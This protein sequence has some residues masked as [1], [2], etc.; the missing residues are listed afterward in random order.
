MMQAAYQ[1]FGSEFAAL[2]SWVMAKVLWD[3]SLKVP[4]L[5]DDFICGYY[6]HAAGDI[7]AY[8]DLLYAT[9][10]AHLDTMRKPEGGIRYPMTA[11]FLS[12][13]FLDEATRIFASAEEHCPYGEAHRRVELAKLPILYVKLMQGPDAWAD[14]Y[15]AVLAEF[16]AIARR[17]KVQYLREG[18]PDLEE[19]LKGWR[20]SV[21]VKQSML[22]IKEGEV[23]IRPLAP[24]WRFATDPKDVG[25]KESW[26][27][28]KLD[29]GRWAVV[30][31]DKGNGWEAQ[32]FPD[33][34]GLGWYRQQFT[35]PAGPA[36]KHAYLYFGAVDEDAWV[37]LN[38]KQV[39]EH[40]CAS[41]G[42]TPDQIWI[43]PF[44]FDAA[45]QLRPGQQNTVAVR[46]LN[47]LGM[48]G[49]YLPAHLVLADRELDA[50]LIQALI[51][52]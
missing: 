33:Y 30:R 2:R 12:K 25:V 4:D 11:P 22:E 40:S 18:G 45:P 42:L 5:V 38:G 3:P 37:Y 27:G 31:S 23:T 32:G 44:V 29:D 13:S 26:F 36:R 35:L 10:A 8:W 21:R 50:P 28:E 14:Q 48:G 19:K 24:E 9:K 46:V 20:D 43:T 39:F 41:T 51:A 1:G 52:K 49:I 7:R 47:R 6:G 15:A 17:E 34:T 16:E